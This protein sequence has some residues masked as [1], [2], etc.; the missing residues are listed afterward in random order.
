MIRLCA[1]PEAL[2]SNASNALAEDANTALFISD[3]TLF[4]VALKHY[5]G[6]LTL[7]SPPCV[8]N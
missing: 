2:S 7:P 4:E 3:A 6:K 5:S 1:E 8:I